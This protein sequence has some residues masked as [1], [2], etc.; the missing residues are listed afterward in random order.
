MAEDQFKKKGPVFDDFEHWGGKETMPHGGTE[1]PSF[2][3]PSTLY[4]LPSLHIFCSILLHH[5][6]PSFTFGPCSNPPSLLTMTIFVSRPRK[7]QLLLNLRQ[8]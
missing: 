8:M 3:S 6:A 7:I 4:S 1:P 5:F 2:H